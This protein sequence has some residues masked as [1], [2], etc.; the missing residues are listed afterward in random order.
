MHLMLQER[1]IDLRLQGSPESNT[2]VRKQHDE[3][4][5]GVGLVATSGRRDGGVRWRCGGLPRQE[6]WEGR[7]VPTSRE[8]EGGRGCEETV[9]L[10]FFQNEGLCDLNKWWDELVLNYNHFSRAKT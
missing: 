3:K 7:V 10:L 9:G 1:R 2:D 4:Y 5:I 6:E 8:H